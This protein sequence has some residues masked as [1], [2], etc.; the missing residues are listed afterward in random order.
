MFVTFIR[1]EN[2]K[3]LINQ[4]QL[5]ASGMQGE[6]CLGK[7]TACYRCGRI[8]Y[9]TSMLWS[10]STQSVT[11]LSYKIHA[12]GFK[13]MAFAVTS[14]LNCPYFSGCLPILNC[15]AV[16]LRQLF[17]ITCVCDFVFL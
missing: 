5:V 7:E 13:G 3:A 16:I 2:T 11:I 6:T 9:S 4:M 12:A 1:A 17:V 8:I 10:S 14:S 15:S